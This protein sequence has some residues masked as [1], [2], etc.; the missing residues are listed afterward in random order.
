MM[1]NDADELSAPAPPPKLSQFST[2]IRRGRRTM[3]SEVLRMRRSIAAA[4]VT[5][6]LAS[7]QC[8]AVILYRSEQRNTSAPTGQFANAGWHHQTTFGDFLAAPVASQWLL[9]AQHVGPPSIIIHQ[10]T[11][12]SV[13]QT[14]SGSGPG[15]IDVPNTDLRL[16]KV[17]GS[18]PSWAQMWDPSVDGSE[19]GR[20]LF[21]AGRGTQ[22]GA[23]V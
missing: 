18:F 17:Q 7:S 20:T 3:A 13:D 9:T 19:I 1:Q 22:R 11:Q 4:V 14:Y 6:L 23:P 5:V 16:W 21:V 2:T 15:W 12:Y 8:F 10:G